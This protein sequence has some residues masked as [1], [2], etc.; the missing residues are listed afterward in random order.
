MVEL[1][2]TLTEDLQGSILVADEGINGMVAGSEAALDS[3]ESALVSIPAFVGM[4]FK[5]SACV[6]PPFRKMKV[7]Q[8]AEIVPLG[9]NGVDTTAGGGIN[10]SPADWRELIKREDVVLLDNRN[11]FEFRLGRF[12]NAADPGVRNF[13]DFPEYVKEHLHEWQRNGKSVAMYCTGGIRCEKTSAWMR[14]FDVPVYQLDGG[15]LNY[16]KQMPDAE[17]DWEGECFVFDNRIAIDTKLKETN[18]T[19]EDVYEGEPDGEWRLRR[20]RQLHGA[21][22]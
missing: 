19:L 21:E 8:K 15:I 18:T 1:L 9:I 14:E 10:V 7:R 3:F 16:F 20:A 13:R 5:R 4:P 12:R 22:D 2:R 6:T 17:Q 11:S